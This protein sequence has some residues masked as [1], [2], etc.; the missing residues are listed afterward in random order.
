V[1]RIPKLWNH[2]LVVPKI[3]SLVI[4]ELLFGIPIFCF[5]FNN[6]FLFYWIF[7]VV[8]GFQVNSITF[9]ES[10]YHRFYFHLIIL[11]DGPINWWSCHRHQTMIFGLK[12]KISNNLLIS[13]Q[14]KTFTTRQCGF[15][16]HKRSQLMIHVWGKLCHFIHYNVQYVLFVM[17]YITLHL[18][19]GNETYDIYII[20]TIT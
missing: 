9:V 14:C 4:I 17:A 12:I 7:L 13:S 19:L 2:N 11:L 15:F 5:F 20:S 8:L 16:A 18:T 1:K 6:I 10:L 3:E